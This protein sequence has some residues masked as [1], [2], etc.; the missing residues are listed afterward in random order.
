MDYT[1]KIN[2]LATLIEESPNDVRL[3]IERGRLYHKM[4]LLDKAMNDFISVMHIDSEN[5]E[6]QAQIDFINEIFRFRYND[7]YNP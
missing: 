2:E 4:G 3:L 7:L 6:A 1:D 5:V